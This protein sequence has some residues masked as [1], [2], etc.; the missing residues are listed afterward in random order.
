[1]RNRLIL[2]NSAVAFALALVVM[3]T[4]HE[5]AH[6][7]AAILQGQ[8]PVIYSGSEQVG[9]ATVRSRVLIAAAGPLGSLLSGLV[10]LSFPQVSRRRVFLRLLILWFGLLSVQEFAGYLFVGMFGSVGDVAIIYS[11]LSTPFLVKLVILIIGAGMT[12]A[13]GRLATLRLLEMTDPRGLPAP[14][15]RRL[16]LFAWI[17]GVTMVALLSLPRTDPRP[18]WR[19]AALTF[20]TISNGRRPSR[21]PHGPRGALGWL[22][23]EGFARSLRECR[24]SAMQATAKPLPLPSAGSLSG[25]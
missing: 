19:L 2:V 1:V 11:L 6:G 22:S 13:L 9:A 18:R 10:V 15:L 3:I 23:P 24:R 4:L 5:L 17:T 14:E 21:H 7:V 8:T 20:A 16:G 25:S 12:A